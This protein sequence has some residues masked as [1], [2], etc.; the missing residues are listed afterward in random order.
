[1]AYFRCS[2]GGGSSS[3]KGATG[4]FITN[5]TAATGYKVTLGFRPIQVCIQIDSSTDPYSMRYDENISQTKYARQS[6]NTSGWRN[7]PETS[8]YGFVS[9]DDDGFT[10]YTSTT[11]SANTK[12]W[13][14]FAVG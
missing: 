12:K 6:Y 4:S 3:T 2:S 1:M 7:I 9:I 10:V 8:G 11:S 14:Y 5:T 13:W